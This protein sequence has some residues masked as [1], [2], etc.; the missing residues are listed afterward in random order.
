MW[1]SRLRREWR[2]KF[3][4]HG[5][6][7]KGLS[8]EDENQREQKNRGDHRHHAIDAIVI[9]LSTRSV[10][11]AWERREK[12]A[13]AERKADGSP[14]WNTADDEQMETYRRNNPLP[15]P[16]PYQTREEFR[17]A[18]E[19]AVFGDEKNPRPIC[20]RPVKR[21]LI[22]ALH[23]ATQYG[24]VVDRWVRDGKVHEQLVEGRV[25]IRQPILGDQPGDFL[26]PSHLR[27]PRPEKE[28]EAIVRLARR[29]RIGKRGLDEEGA[30]KEAK[31]VVRSPAYS[32]ALVEP[33]PEKGGIVRDAG[34]KRLLREVLTSRGLDPDNYTKGDLK[35]SIAEKGPLRHRSRPDEY[36]GVPIHAVTLLWSNSEPVAYER[37]EYDYKTGER[38]KSGR[39]NTIRLYDGQN[40]HHIEIRTSKTKQGT[41]SWSGNVVSGD[42]ASK[43]KRNKLRA[44]RALGVPKP[45]AFRERDK[46]GRPTMSKAE[47]A[48]WRPIIAAIESSHPLVNRADDNALGGRFVMSLCEGET[49]YCRRWQPKQGKAPGGP[50]GDPAYWIVAKVSESEGIVLVAHWDAR[51]ARGAKDANGK[52]IEGSRRDDWTVSPGDLAKCGPAPGEAPR[53]VRVSPLGFVALLE[54]D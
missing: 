14:R 30:L 3:D 45:A 35:K 20:H 36:N 8:N 9:G 26:K 48:R 15:L 49:I 43:R 19:A 53:K 41:E 54:K 11:D 37:L 51:R 33:K 16:S 2:L 38:R 17:A 50:I 5:A 21:K 29:L 6:R 52:E 24:P 31:R 22:G 44:F 47:R 42:V 40:N 46:E 1:T 7:A 23:K 27:V 12:D 13:D 25:T 4:T 39:A 10:Q 28:D 18:V 34:L 32:P